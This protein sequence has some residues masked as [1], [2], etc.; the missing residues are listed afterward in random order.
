MRGSSTTKAVAGAAVA[1]ALS[2]FDIVGAAGGTAYAAL[3]LAGLRGSGLFTINLATGRAT[4]V[5][6]IRGST[7][8]A[9]AIRGTIPGT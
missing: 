4:L 3:R 1:L 2:S 6:P 7:L 5:R 9:L 8:V